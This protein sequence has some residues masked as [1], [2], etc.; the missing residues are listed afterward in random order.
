MSKDK[1]QLMENEE[2]WRKE[3]LKT[4]QKIERTLDAQKT[5]EKHDSDNSYFLTK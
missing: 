5:N 4:P 2:L 3:I 1:K